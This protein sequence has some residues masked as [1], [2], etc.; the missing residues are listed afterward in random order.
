[1]C[2]SAQGSLYPSPKKTC[3]RMCIQWPSF[4]KK[5]TWTKGHWPPDDLWSQVCWGHMSDSTRGSSSPSPMTIYIKYVDTANLLSKTWTK[6]HWPLDALWPHVCWCHIHVWLY[7]IVIVSKSQG[8]TSMYV[9][10]VI[11]F[12][13]YHTLHTYIHTTYIIHNTYYVQNEW[14]HSLFLNSVQTRQ[15][16]DVFF[17]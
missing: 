2:D 12:T 1:M 11:N 5:K 6:G 3:E 7:S 10:T 16:I 8:S 4:Q 15:K 13:I 9:D 17:T 14:S